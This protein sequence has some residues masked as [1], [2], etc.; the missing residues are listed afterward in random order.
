MPYKFFD[1]VPSYPL[2][3]IEDW[4]VLVAE[5]ESGVEQRAARWSFP[6]R[7]WDLVWNAAQRTTE[8]E[9]VRKFF[10]GVRGKTDTFMWREP[11]LTSR[12]SIYMGIGTSVR[13]TWVLPVWGAQSFQ[14]LVNSIVR[15]TGFSITS[16]TAQ[17]SLHL[18]TFT[19]SV[20]APNEFVSMNYTNGFF[21]PLV[22]FNSQFTHKLI[23]GGGY[24]RGN[25]SVT[26]RET[27]EE[28]PAS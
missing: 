5:M 18:L 11:T 7:E 24:D 28:M 27:K 2:S 9:T 14:V 17:N 20:P 6:R 23:K 3:E 12:D 21:I 13:T 4:R 8:V 16:A 19:S 10:S 22:R 15:T 25:V 1:I 26:F